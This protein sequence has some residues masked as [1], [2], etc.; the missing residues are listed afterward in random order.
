MTKIEL[1]NKAFTC[2][3][4][5][6]SKLTSECF[7]IGGFT[8]PMIRHLMNQLG[9]IST[10]YLEVGVLRGALFLATLYKNHNLETSTAVDS[11]VE[12]N[13]EK[14][15]KQVLLDNMRQFSDRRFGE[16]KVDLIPSWILLDQDC[17]TVPVPMHKPI[18][19]YLFDGPHSLEEQAKAITYYVPAMADEFILCIDDHNWP[20][21]SKGTEEGIRAAG[22]TVLNSWIRESEDWHNGYAVF[23]LKK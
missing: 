2:A 8:S 17:W 9:S 10:N 21:V 19:L 23:L 14:D 7:E 16:P 1:I 13:E 18:D 15:M 20:Q 12:F 3:E 5:L 11:F 4:R 6:E 22:L